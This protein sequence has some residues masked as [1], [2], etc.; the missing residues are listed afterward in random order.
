MARRDGRGTRLSLAPRKARD[1]M[2]ANP[3]S[4]PA[5]ATL[6]EAVEALT[7]R[8]ISG[9]PVI[10]EAGRPVGVISRSDVLAHD[11]EEVE[12]A[13][14][15]PRAG[16]AGHEARPVRVREVMTPVV[17][18][19]PPDAPAS[20]VVRDMVELR[21][22]RLFVVEETGTL[23]GVI[24]ALDVLRHLTPDEAVGGGTAGPGR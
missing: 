4:I 21:I 17:F 18:F 16:H 5:Q 10:D 15:T 14:P 13:R 23:V 24:S 11:R 2:S 19:V 6:R 7:R 12:Y 20:R 9:A 22:H 8:A 1:L 3:I